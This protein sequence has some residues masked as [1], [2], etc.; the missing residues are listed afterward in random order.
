MTDE[1]VNEHDDLEDDELS[2]DDLPDGTSDGRVLTAFGIL[3]R[4]YLAGCQKV[5]R[6]RL[7]KAKEDEDEDNYV[8][9]L[10]FR[11]VVTP[12]DMRDSD[13][14]SHCFRPDKMFSGFAN[15]EGS[16]SISVGDTTAEINEEN[17]HRLVVP[18]TGQRTIV[19]VQAPDFAIDVHDLVTDEHLRLRPIEGVILH[20]IYPNKKDS[21]V[22][23]IVV[24]AMGCHYVLGGRD[25]ARHY[26]KISIIHNTEQEGIF[27][28]EAHDIR[29]SQTPD[30]ILTA[31]YL[32]DEGDEPPDLK[33]IEEAE[34]LPL[35]EAVEAGSMVEV[36]GSDEN[37]GSYTVVESKSQFD[38][39]D[40]KPRPS[41]DPDDVLQARHDSQIE[42]LWAFGNEFGFIDEICQFAGL[43]V[44]KEMSKQMFDVKIPEKGYIDLRVIAEGF[45]HTAL[46]KNA[47]RATD[48]TNKFNWRLL[49]YAIEHGLHKE[50]ES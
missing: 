12:D 31:S 47:Q 23:E 15:M 22:A 7:I 19:K 8:I 28:G 18:A 20:E 43:D 30:R 36:E 38:D 41:S 26:Y 4:L 48:P 27:A 21:K 42:A 46:L 14:F 2:D 1:N 3:D 11:F 33:T 13:H 9:D 5:P 39:E 17:K 35:D 49:A 40:P 25:W 44:T 50:I 34:G 24:I 10:F 45:K 6:F 16:V 37:D 29:I 32:E